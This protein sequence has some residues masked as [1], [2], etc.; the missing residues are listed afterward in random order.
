VAVDLRT[1]EY[2][3]INHTGAILWEDLASGATRD[4]LVQ[5]L[6]DAYGVNP[7]DAGVDVDGFV[8]SLRELDL[9]EP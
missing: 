1:S 7:A 3:G 4:T 5:R 6:T 9:L 8:D 2:V